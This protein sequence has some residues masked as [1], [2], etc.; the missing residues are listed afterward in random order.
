MAYPGNGMEGAYR[1]NISDV[2]AMLNEYHRS[3]FC[4]YN[5]SGRKYD[6]SIFDPKNRQCVQDWCY[7]PDHNP[8]P[9]PLLLELLQHMHKFL[10]ADPQNVVVVHCLA[11]KG[12]TGTIIACYMLYSGLFDKATEALNFFAFKRSVTVSGVSYPGQVR[13]VTYTQKLLNSDASALSAISSASRTP[14]F[15]KYIALTRVPKLYLSMVSYAL[16]IT[17]VVEIYSLARKIPE[18]VLSSAW[19]S[20]PE[21]YPYDPRWEGPGADAHSNDGRDVP[22][23]EKPIIIPVNKA[24]RGDVLITLNHFQAV[25]KQLQVVFRLNFHTGFLHMDAKRITVPRQRQLPQSQRPRGA[26]I[27]EEPEQLTALER[28]LLKRK[29]DEEALQ[30]VKGHSLSSLPATG[31]RPRTFTAPGPER[32][33]SDSGGNNDVLYTVTFGKESIDCITSDN[34]FPAS[35]G[36]VL[37]YQVGNIGTNPVEEENFRKAAESEESLLRHVMEERPPPEVRNGEMCFFG[38]QA[39]EKIARA[40]SQ[41][42]S[43]VVCGVHTEKS[44]WLVKRGE[45]VKNWKK[46]WFVLRDSLSYFKS[47]KAGAPTGVIPLESILS[48]V[49][50]TAACDSVH[51]YCFELVVDVK[52][53]DTNVRNVGLRSYVMCAENEAEKNEWTEAIDA[54]RKEK[55]ER[56]K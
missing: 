2:S 8:P 30:F 18:M 4:I 40:R 33:E 41:A 42:G 19:A 34:R 55:R 35:F 16:G 13:Y 37:A 45:K 53:A 27:G 5:L 32:E 43:T 3:H 52:S 21:T 14:I 23:P 6:Y 47:A 48:V 28:E 36:C 20:H 50:T 1:N 56:A 12:R 31:F 39:S 44:G 51:Q 15:L 49:T 9:L 7:F 26:S 17:P 24:L 22:P 10:M 25:S 11:G 29:K 38:A 46:R 54:A